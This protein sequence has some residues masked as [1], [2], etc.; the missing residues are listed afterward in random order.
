MNAVF[1][2]TTLLAVIYLSEAMP[3]KYKQELMSSITDCMKKYGMGKDE[4]VAVMRSFIPSE[5]TEKKCAVG[6]VMEKLGYIK[7]LTMDWEAVKSDHPS[8]YDTP[9]K[10]EKANKVADACVKIVS[11]KEADLCTLG[12]KGLACLHD[13]SQKL[14]LPIPDFSFE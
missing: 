1:C 7:D 8:K 6:C 3:S 11:G 14:Q 5:D 13:Q 4:V 12:L 2:V 10:V 9:D